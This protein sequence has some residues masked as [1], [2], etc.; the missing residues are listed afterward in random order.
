MEKRFQIHNLEKETTFSQDNIDNLQFYKFEF[1]QK[2]KITL[3][4]ILV[5]N[6]YLIKRFL[7]SP[8]PKHI[9][10]L[11]PMENMGLYM[12]SLDFSLFSCFYL[13]E[14]RQNFV[15]KQ[16][17]FFKSFNFS[18][19]T[20]INFIYR[21]NIFFGNSANSLSYLAIYVILFMHQQ[22]FISENYKLY[23]LPF[24]VIYNYC[25]TINKS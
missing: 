18:F 8:S 7:L 3:L 23:W 4:I 6:I 2:K 21:G 22:Y 16:Y 17:P 9:R 25:V 15:K 19:W 13:S 24:C 11:K 1:L 12:F 14:S 5:M 20:E 10:I